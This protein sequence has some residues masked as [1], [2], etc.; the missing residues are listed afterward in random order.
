MKTVKMSLTSWSVKAGFEGV[1]SCDGYGER[2]A[3][4]S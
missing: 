3:T 4:V 1:Q 2:A